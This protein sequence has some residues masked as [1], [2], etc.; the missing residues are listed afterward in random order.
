MEAIEVGSWYVFSGAGWG[1]AGVGSS[2]SGGGVVHR[3]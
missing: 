2:G 3:G 1:R